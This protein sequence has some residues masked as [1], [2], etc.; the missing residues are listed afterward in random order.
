MS[1]ARQVPRLTLGSFLW[2][3]VGDP[4]Q[5]KACLGGLTSAVSCS[6]LEKVWIF[7]VE[8]GKQIVF[9][10]FVSGGSIRAQITGCCTFKAFVSPISFNWLTFLHHKLNWGFLFIAILH[11][12]SIYASVQFDQKYINVGIGHRSSFFAANGLRTI[13]LYFCKQSIKYPF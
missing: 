11:P 10:V 7:P 3:W 1:K 12:T 6:L 5:S 4:D 2:E 8:T 9:L 13:L